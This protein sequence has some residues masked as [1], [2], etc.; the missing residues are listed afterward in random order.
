V[1]RR[2][3]AKARLPSTG[4]SVGVDITPMK[5]PSTDHRWGG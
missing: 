3:V 5:A 4:Q 2:H 1:E